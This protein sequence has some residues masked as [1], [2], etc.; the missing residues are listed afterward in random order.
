MLSPDKIKI[1]QI[2]SSDK[3]GIY[4]IEPLPRGYG[5]S[6][7]NALRRV[8][9]SSIMG[10]AV[11]RIK[12][13]GADYKYTT[14]EGVAE[15][16]FQVVLNVKQLVFR[17]TDKNFEDYKI[18]IEKK[19]IG[20]VTL[21]DCDIPNGITV[22]DPTQKIATITDATTTFKAEIHVKNGYGYESVEE[23]SNKSSVVGEIDVDSV[24]S[25]IKLVNFKVEDTRV[26]S[27]TELDSLT[28]DI[29]TDGSIDTFES[30]KYASA[31]LRDFFAVL[32]EGE[33]VIR[34]ESE[35][36]AN[37]TIEPTAK[38]NIEVYIEELNLPT[39][40]VNAVKKHGVNTLEDLANLDEDQLLSIRNLGE[41]SIREIK[42]LL[43]KEGYR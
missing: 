37:E 25:P 26:G 11:T 30:L 23:R 31:Q 28:L 8:L 24:F 12:I 34:E 18:Q 41:K 27:N 3:Q 14:I 43:K 5:Q 6:L 36:E 20:D 40:T 9:L 35:E 42:K 1:K 29:S 13:E 10:A 21:S 32:S 39:R 15:D 22:V 19:G 7:G 33:K 4:A 16:I 2:E 17:I 38:K